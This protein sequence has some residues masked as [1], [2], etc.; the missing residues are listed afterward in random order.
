MS[1][2]RKLSERIEQTFELFRLVLIKI[3][4]PGIIAPAIIT[5]YVKFYVIGLNGNESFNL[6]APM[7]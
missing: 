4:V 6:P 3:S 2:Y 1:T 5:S 7:M